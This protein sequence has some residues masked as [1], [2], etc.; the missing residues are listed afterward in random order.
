MHFA[1]IA[2][3]YSE[4]PFVI[5]NPWSFYLPPNPVILPK[6]SIE[7]ALSLDLGITAFYQSPLDWGFHLMCPFCALPVYLQACSQRGP[8]HLQWLKGAMQYLFLSLATPL[9][10][11]WRP[12]QGVHDWGVDYFA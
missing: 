10:S 6:S 7:V 2:L 1:S 9:G 3:C 12:V 5:L 8:T 4:P 11:H